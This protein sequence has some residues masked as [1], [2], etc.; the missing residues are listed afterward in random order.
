MSLLCAF[1][2]M[3]LELINSI[4]SEVGSTVQ[5]KMEYMCSN[6]RCKHGSRIIHESSRPLR[7]DGYITLSVLHKKDPPKKWFWKLF[8]DRTSQPS[9]RI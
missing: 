6:P 3:P 8:G 9:L 2:N 5:E 1:C 7:K 4:E